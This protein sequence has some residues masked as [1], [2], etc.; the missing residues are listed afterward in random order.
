MNRL[1]SWANG[2]FPRKGGQGST[3]AYE[4]S[5]CELIPRLLHVLLLHVMLVAGGL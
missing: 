4:R 5:D 2:L 1:A 3:L